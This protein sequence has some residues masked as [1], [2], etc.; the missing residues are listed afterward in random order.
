MPRA[1]LR[2]LGI[3]IGRHPPGPYN[4]ITDVPGILVGHTTL[5]Y[6]APRMA[7]TGVTVIVPRGGEIHGDHCFAAIHA[8][9]GNGEMTGSHWV[10]ESGLL[11]T[12]LAITNTHQVGVVRD[13][14]VEYEVNLDPDASWLLP[15]V[16]ETYDGW[17]ND[18]DGFHVTKEH[19]FAALAAAGPGPVA[20]GNVGGGTGMI[21]HE[22]KGGIGTS[23]R[24]VEAPGG[25][26]TVGALV[27]ANYGARADLRVDGVPVG[28]YLPYDRVPSPRAAATPGGS[29]IVVVATDAPLLPI[30]CR[31]LA[32]R[33]TVGLARV[34]GV[35]HNGSGDIFLAFATGN[36]LPSRATAP[37]SLQMLPHGEM[38]PLFEATAET[39]EEAILNALTAAETMQGFQGRTVHALPLDELVQLV[40]QERSR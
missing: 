10:A 31:R 15:L 19:V 25:P 5:V 28:R 35:G 37:L 34:G 18:I 26:Y 1:R 24:V 9:N 2:D 6:D 8:F 11:G 33:A 14:L 3:T 27:Q 39:V 22:F 12:P 36:H 40:R 17:L 7:R 29:I 16:A 21:C 32:Q 23:S 13:A 20:E 30:Q 38:N 4:A